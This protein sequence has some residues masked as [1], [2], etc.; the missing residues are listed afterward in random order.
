MGKLKPE[1]CWL[2]LQIQT[3]KKQ[4]QKKKYRRV[5]FY[6]GLKKELFTNVCL[7]F[8]LR[9]ENVGFG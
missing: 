3:I 5:G 2:S 6:A 7:M 4:M 1:T 9:M 8:C